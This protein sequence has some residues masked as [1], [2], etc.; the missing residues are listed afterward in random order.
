MQ[1]FSKLFNRSRQ[2]GKQGTDTDAV[3]SGAQDKRIVFVTVP[4]SGTN[5]LI[6]IFLGGLGGRHLLA[7][8]GY[9]PHDYLD[10]W[11]LRSADGLTMTSTHLAPSRINLKL[12]RQYAGPF[13]LHLR[14]PRSVILSWTHHVR[15][16]AA[17]G[18]WERHLVDICWEGPTEEDYL[19]WDFDRLLD[20]N[21][22]NFLPVVVT[23][24]EGWLAMADSFHDGEVL[25][26]TYPDLIEDSEKLIVRSAE[27]Y[28]VDP[29]P[30]L[31]FQADYHD[32]HARTGR[33][34]EWADVFNSEQLDFA[35]RAVPQHLLDK[36]N[37]PTL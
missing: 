37:K 33:V 1:R 24:L 21:L 20:W 6:S 27:H 8:P 18:P 10:V 4:K 16:Y 34:D 23:W 26:T 11:K 36:V 14:D 3:S 17:K 22:R 12:L 31:A 2:S 9:F 32:P 25:V 15:S 35:R 7:S 13:H 5:F 19:D 29:A 30:I 28:G